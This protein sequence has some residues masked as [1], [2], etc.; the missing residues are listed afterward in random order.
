MQKRIN[1]FPLILATFVL[2]SAPIIL[3]SCQENSNPKHTSSSAAKSDNNKKGDI[4]MSIKIESPAFRN[5]QRIPE[6]YTADGQDISVPLNWSNIPDG[7]KELAIICDDPDAPT[8]HP[9]VHW[10]IYKIPPSITALKENIPKQ[11]RLTDPPNALQG[12]NSWGKIGYNGPAP[13]KGH[14]THHYYFKIYALDTK[15]NVNQALD[16]QQLLEAMDGH[17]IA[18]GQLVG[19]YER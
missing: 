3:I 9:W 12:K 6:K 19:T 15:L 5:N 18:Q 17:I 16:K 10:L 11:P 8:T 4:P 7:T 1:N 13:P 14:G 2:I